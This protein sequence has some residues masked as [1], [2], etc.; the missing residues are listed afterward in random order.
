MLVLRT[1][2]KVVNVSAGLADS[3]KSPKVPTYRGTELKV[4]ICSK[5]A[6]FA[7]CSLYANPYFF[8]SGHFNTSTILS[9]QEVFKMRGFLP[10][11][12]AG[13]YRLH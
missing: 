10:P 4:Q 2:R 6:A 13:V 9:V 3:F 11:A 1:K 12:S 7:K 5:K 8:A